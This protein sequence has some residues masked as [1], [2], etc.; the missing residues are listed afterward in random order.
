M[1]A[2]EVTISGM[3]YDRL[4]RTTQNV[5]LIGEAS[6]TG[7]GVGG[8]PMP[9]GPGTPPERP[10]GQPIHPI[11]GPPGIELPPGPGFP[12]VAG[13]PLPPIISVPPDRP[14][15]PPPGSPPLMIGGSQPVQP[16]T[17]PPAI[18]VEYPGVGK[19]V[20]PLP[21][22]TVQPSATQPAT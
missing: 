18:I 5:V 7:L 3:L 1:A 19:V 4:N 17:P 14:N 2:V 15:T 22:D 6:L 10:P 11:W 9:P 13:H 8:G 16:I 20:V 12:P 21:T